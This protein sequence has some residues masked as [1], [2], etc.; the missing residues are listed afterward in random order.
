VD[1]VEGANEFIS[2]AAAGDAAEESGVIDGEYHI[3]EDAL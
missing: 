3:L 1:D 2:T